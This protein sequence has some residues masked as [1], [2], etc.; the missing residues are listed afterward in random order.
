MP[1]RSRFLTVLLIILFKKRYKEQQNF[2][3]LLGHSICKHIFLWR[4]HAFIVIQESKKNRL[5]AA[6]ISVKSG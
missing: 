1:F 5:V 4:R 3:I 6:Y 2:E